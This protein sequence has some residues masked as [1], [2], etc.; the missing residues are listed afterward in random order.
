MTAGRTVIFSGLTVI[1]CL[2]ALL[3]FPVGFLQSIAA[4]ATSAVAMALLVAFALLPAVF[5][6]LG[7]NINRWQ[8]VRTS[9][10]SSKDG[11]L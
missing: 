8:I 1:V 3:L 5:A 2:L 6:V 10:K 4:G 9:K 11:G 7:K